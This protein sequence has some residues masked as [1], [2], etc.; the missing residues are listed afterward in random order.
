MR[1]AAPQRFRCG[2][3]TKTTPKG[4]LRAQRLGLFECGGAERA[5]RR[6]GNVAMEGSDDP[7]EKKRRVEAAA[8]GN[9]SKRT[10]VE[11]PRRPPSQRP[12]SESIAAS[13]G[14]F[15]SMGKPRWHVAPMVDQSE[16]PFRMLCRRYGAE[17]AYTPMLHARLF[18]EGAKY[19]REHFTTC[20]ADRPLITQF[21]A[22]D[23][24]VLLEAARH[25]EAH[26]DAVDINFGCPQR[27][28]KKGNYGAFLMDDLDR[29]V[30]L[31]R[32]ARA[33]ARSRIR[34]VR[35]RPC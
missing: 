25:V 16:L 10:L 9:P 31:R 1:W 8:S 29:V 11:V 17:C 34:S 28:A 4:G 13:W 14:F 21:C 22:N 33:V 20:A 27:I 35:L 3:T 24:Q 5:A 23:P 26:C 32:I 6:M 2:G 19:R 12:S 7:V 30:G 15:E 18:V